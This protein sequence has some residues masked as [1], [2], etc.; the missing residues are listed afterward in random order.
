MIPYTLPNGIK[1]ILESNKCH[2]SVTINIMFRVGSRDEPSEY[3]G[4]THF[5]EHMFFKGTK[6]RP[7]A[8]LISGAIDQFGGLINAVTSYDVTYYYI[9]I[10]ADQLELALDVLSDMLFN[11]LFSSK[12]IKSEKEVV[13]EEIQ[14]YQSNPSRH[15]NTILED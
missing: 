12:D 11:S 8:S 5:A 9:K 2:Q 6:N 14:M 7:Q 10:D 4:L 3:Y 15:V 1:C 13:V